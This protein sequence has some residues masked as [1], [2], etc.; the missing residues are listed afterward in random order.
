MPPLTSPVYSSRHCGHAVLCLPGYKFVVRQ[1]KLRAYPN[2][3]AGF[4]FFVP[5][6]RPSNLRTIAIAQLTH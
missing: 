4:L 5:L 6:L 1:S 3:Q 2:H